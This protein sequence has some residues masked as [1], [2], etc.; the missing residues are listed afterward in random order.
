MTQQRTRKPL[1]QVN[2]PKIRKVLS[3]NKREVFVGQVF[4]SNRDIVLN[5]EHR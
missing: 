5:T 3:L 4:H 1:T 2:T